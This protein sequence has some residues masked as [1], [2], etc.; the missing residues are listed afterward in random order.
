MKL[1][2]VFSIEF[3]DK[4]NRINDGANLD[5]DLEVN[6]FIDI[7]DI[8]KALNFE[9]EFEDNMMGSGKINGNRIIIDSSENS[10]RQRF[11]MAHELGHAVQN[12][13]NA[14]RNDDSE[15]YSSE[16]RRKEVFANTFAAQFL[17][18]KVLVKEAINESITQNGF[19][20]LKLTPNNIDTIVSEV[21]AKLG[22]SKIAMKYRIENLNIFIPAKEQ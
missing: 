5:P 14:N 22:V 15:D 10:A 7:K 12:D 16:D 11:S 13:R 18:P 21:S 1:K 2:E 3:I 19:D 9:V 20:R 4:L 6:G 8:L 17:M